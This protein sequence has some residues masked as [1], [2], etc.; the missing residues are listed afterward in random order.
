MIGAATFAADVIVIKHEIGNTPSGWVI[1]QYGLIG[2]L[3]LIPVIYPTDEAENGEII[4]LDLLF[5]GIGTAI[6]GN[7]SNYAY[8]K[9]VTL[10]KV[11][12]IAILLY[13]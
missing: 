13:V 3:M 11:G 5:F 2:M 8:N 4:P 6:L 10:Y 7:I 9:G 1:W 12:K